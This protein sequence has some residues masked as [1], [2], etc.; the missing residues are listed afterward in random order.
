[1]GVTGNMEFQ[2]HKENSTDYSDDNEAVEDAGTYIQAEKVDYD[3]V[4]ESLKGFIESFKDK[5]QMNII[6]ILE[7]A[8]NTSQD[9]SDKQ[10]IERKYF[11]ENQDESLSQIEYNFGKGMTRDRKL[12]KKQL[13]KERL[14]FEE[15]KKSEKQEEMTKIIIKAKNEFV[16]N[17]QT[18][19]D[20]LK[21][22][23]SDNP[24]DYVICQE[25]E[26]PVC[27]TEMLPPVKIWQCASGHA[28]CQS[29]K[30][31]PNINRK[32]PTCRQ[33]IMGRATV[34]EKMA[35]SLYYKLTGREVIDNGNGS[36]DD[37]EEDPDETES[38]SMPADILEMLY[39][40]RRQQ[41][42]TF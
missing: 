15:G 11:N 30:R 10:M 9:L 31:N 3:D 12:M 32:C 34:L 14:E 2:A 42:R 26:C 19:L 4:E 18:I 36:G 27:L 38:E 28:V 6:A 1:M 8:K 33:G 13:L 35:G 23:L 25:L 5:S 20:E 40:P 16:A 29:C 39:L 21:S 7:E 22:E 37:V 41:S 17:Q 24:T